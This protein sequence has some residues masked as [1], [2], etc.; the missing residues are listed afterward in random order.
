MKVLNHNIKEEFGDE[1]YSPSW[2]DC[3]ENSVIL[4]GIFSDLFSIIQKIS[5]YFN[6][7]YD[8]GIDRAQYFNIGNFKNIKNFDYDSNYAISIFLIYKDFSDSNGEYK[9]LVNLRNKIYHNRSATH[10]YG[11]DVITEELLI[12]K[13]YEIFSV[14]RKVM[15]SIYLD[16]CIGGMRK[17]V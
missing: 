10:L 15:F 8:L 2:L 12:E 16:D 4:K 11:E 3:S 6:D 13:I 14:V 9:E 5:V 1:L 17:S 7:K